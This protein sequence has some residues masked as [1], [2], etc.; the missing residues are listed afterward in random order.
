MPFRIMRFRTGA[1][2]IVLGTI[3][4]LYAVKLL[5]P[6]AIGLISGLITGWWDDFDDWMVEWIVGW[7]DG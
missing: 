6:A 4:G 7:M 5:L 2:Y 3:M 1:V